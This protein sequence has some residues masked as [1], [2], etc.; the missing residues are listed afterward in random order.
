MATSE[1]TAAN[2]NGAP[3]TQETP[4][5]TPTT[6][7]EIRKTK[8]R[9]PALAAGLAI[10]GAALLS[11]AVYGG[12]LWG[13]GADGTGGNTAVPASGE[14]APFLFGAES[15]ANAINMGE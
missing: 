7:H 5:N 12:Y 11:A 15:G 10:G 8:W 6:T 9:L 2:P 1:H 3:D 14:A 4:M 13:S